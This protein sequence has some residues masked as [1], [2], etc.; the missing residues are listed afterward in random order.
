MEDNMVDS[1]VMDIFSCLVTKTALTVETSEQMA[2][3]AVKDK[4]KWWHPLIS[5]HSFP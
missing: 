1:K 5:S 3:Q 2:L 4:S